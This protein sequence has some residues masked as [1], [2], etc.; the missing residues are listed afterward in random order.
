MEPIVAA[1]A[2]VS[3]RGPEILLVHRPKYDDWSFPKGKLDPGEHLTTCAV[4]EVAEE[5][6]LDIRLGPPL[7]TQSYQVRN[8][9]EREKQVH[10][11]VARVVGDD[12]VSGYRAN[13]EIDQVRWVQVDKARAMLTYEHDRETLDEWAGLR[14]KSFPVVVLR[15]AK[16]LPRKRWD[17]D[18]RERPLAPL[19]DLQAEEV[20]PVLSAYGVTRVVSSSSTRCWS[21]L[22]PYADLLEVDL[23]VTDELSEQ[24]ATAAGVADILEELVEERE[25]TVVCVHRPVLPLVLEALGV[26]ATKLEP[27]QMLVVHQRRGKVLATEVH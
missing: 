15:H 27:G 9:V 20:V 4:R 11:W 21:T 26:P 7:S 2:V 10:Y 19:G 18:D 24:D 3:R 12:D 14:K 16:A 17:G 6:G 5:T 22:A 13:D 8:G 25:P 23:E 1:G